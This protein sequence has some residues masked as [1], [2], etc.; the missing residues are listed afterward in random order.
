MAVGFYFISVVFS[1][2]FSTFDYRRENEEEKNRERKTRKKLGE[3]YSNY[4]DHD[5]KNISTMSEAKSGCR[6]EAGHISTKQTLLIDC[7]H[8]GEPNSP[9]LD[10]VFLIFVT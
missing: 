9:N 1:I 7:K 8:Q 10:L 3:A 4:K 6:S 5:P 2:S